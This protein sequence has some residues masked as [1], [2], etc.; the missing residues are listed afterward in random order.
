MAKKSH[1]ALKINVVGDFFKRQEEAFTTFNFI[2][3]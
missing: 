3:V 1:S 2:N